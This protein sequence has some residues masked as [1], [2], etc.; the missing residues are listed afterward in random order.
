VADRGLIHHVELWV[1][2]LERARL[3]W[4][5]LLTSLGYEPFQDWAAGCS[6]RLGESYIVIEQSPDL[7]PG[8]HDRRRPGLNH[9]AFRGGSRSQVDELAAQA[10]MHGWS[11]M[12]PGRHPYAGGPEHYAAFLE[13][14]DDFEAE[15]VAS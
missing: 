14:S 15:V 3:S 12:F 1:P 7:V 10:P 2:Q 6:W 4:G 8:P 13:D 11:L 5:W 9:L